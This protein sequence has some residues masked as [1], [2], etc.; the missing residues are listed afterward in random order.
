MMV[1]ATHPPEAAAT[2]Q[3]AEILAAFFNALPKDALQAVDPT[4]ARRVSEFLAAQGY[5]IVF[6]R[7][8]PQEPPGAA[9]Q[10][11]GHG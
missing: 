1:S 5:R 9:N 11:A 10:E 7:W 8:Y 6:D 2:Q 4:V 3:Q